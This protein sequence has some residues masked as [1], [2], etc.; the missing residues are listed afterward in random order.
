MCR[1]EYVRKPT[2]QDTEHKVLMPA[3]KLACAALSCALFLPFASFSVQTVTAVWDPSPDSVAGYNLYFGPSSGVYTNVISVANVTNTPVANLLEGSTYFFVVKA[4]DSSQ[5]ES[6]GSNEASFTVPTNSPATNPPPPNP[7]TNQTPAPFILLSGSYNGLFFEND[8]IRQESAGFFS[9]F[10]NARSNYSGHLQLGSKRYSFKGRI[11]AEG[12]ATNLLVRRNDTKLSI[13][14]QLGRGATSNQ[15]FGRIDNGDWI[16]MLSGDRAVFSR[17]FPSPFIGAYTLIFPGQT[18]NPALPA[19]NGFAAVKVNPQGVARAIA[20]LADGTRASQSAPLSHEGLW[21]FYAPLYAGK[22]SIISWLLL[23]NRETDDINGLVSWIKPTDSSKR[24][25][26]SGFTN[27]LNAFG[28]AYLAPHAPNH[29][30]LTLTSASVLFSDGNLS[31]PF[32]TTVEFDENGHLVATNATP[33]KLSFSSSVG[34]FSGSTTDPHSGQTFQFK[35]AV[36]QKL[37]SG[38]GFLLGTD[39]SASVL[40]SQ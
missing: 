40:L 35:G 26:P 34:T 5:R 16:S 39:E 36:A 33:F 22:G 17:T 23:T 24:Y 14:L 1:P 12:L 37:N 27:E 8:S 15:V 9:L 25:F 29:A 6:V 30:V 10:L 21:P 19:G 32:S 18:N 13:Q 3:L 38:Y 2:S 11:N 31:S 28:S 20:S 7:G 4:F